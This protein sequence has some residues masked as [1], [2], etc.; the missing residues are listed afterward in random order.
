MPAALA[1]G[2]LA[3]SRDSTAR[4]IRTPARDQRASGSRLGEIKTKVKNRPAERDR[5][6]MLAT[7]RAR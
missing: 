3:A 6:R 7:R 5:D 4:I 1:R 2:R